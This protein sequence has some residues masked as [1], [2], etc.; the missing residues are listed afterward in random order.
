MSTTLPRSWPP[1]IVDAVPAF[2]VL[3]VCLGNVCRSPFGERLLAQR[4]QGSGIEVA[5]AGVA[6]MVGAQISPEAAVLLQEYGGTAD[7]FVARQLTPSM[8]READLVL[9][10]TTELRSRVL[11]ETPGALRRTFT[12]LELAALL[13]HVQ[14]A[15][16]AE[17]VAQ[18]AAARSLLG[19]AELD[20]PDPYGRGDEAHARAAS[21]MATAVDRIAA[22]L[23]G[24]PAR[25]AE[26][27]AGDRSG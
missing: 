8:V 21:L 6:A 13:D 24:E 9:T 23:V 18:A 15:P 27:G 26:S 12:V 14:P 3:F 1:S 7:G 11:A 5:S 25:S 4:V 22:A 17:L 20:V 16:P 19:P 10:A 2:R